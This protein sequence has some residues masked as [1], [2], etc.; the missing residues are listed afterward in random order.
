[1]SE[2]NEILLASFT[3]KVFMDVKDLTDIEIDKLA[4]YLDY[5]FEDT[6]KEDLENEI[7]NDSQFD[8]VRDKLRIE[9]K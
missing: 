9:V 4:L 1:M 2:R 6:I 8:E 3:V 5:G 7:K